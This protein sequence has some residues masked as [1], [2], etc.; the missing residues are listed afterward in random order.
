MSP[1]GHHLR[2]IVARGDFRR[3]LTTRLT[4]QFSDG[5][6]Q[7][8]LAGSVLFNPDR[9][10]APL[11]VALGFAILLLPYS[12]VGPFAGVLLDRWSR[13]TVLVWANLVRSAVVPLVAVL[14]WQGREDLLFMLATLVAIGVNRF[15][16]SGLSA[17]LR[18]TSEIEHLATANSLST[19]AGSCVFAVGIGA[20]VGLQALTGADNHG[21]AIVALCSIPGYLLSSALA[22]RFDRFQLGPDAAERASR[23]SAGDVARGLVQGVRHLAERR[24]AGQVLLATTAHR[25]LFGVLL[26]ATLLLYRNYFVAEGFFRSGATGLGQTIAAS[27]AGAFI[28]AAVTPVAIRTLTPRIWVTVLLASTAVVEVLLGA[29]Y[30]VPALLGAVLLIGLAAQG[31]KIVTDTT[32]QAECDDEFQGR[33]FSVYDMMFNVALVV[34]L[35]IGALALPDTGK[36]YAV[37]AAVSAGYALVAIWYGWTSGRWH[38]DHRSPLEPVGGHSA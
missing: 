3:L 26:I 31:I 1:S 29:P 25:L 35:L 32:L 5:I 17:S 15:F 38:R 36:S 14:V 24:G 30:T 7:A 9:H 18:H 8:G 6:F 22:R 19:T 13:R 34:G 2:A 10:T 28:A 20:A 4:S 16:L 27:A 11:D 33:V 21:Y 12:V 37:L 23:S